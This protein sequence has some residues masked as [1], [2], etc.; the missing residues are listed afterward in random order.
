M[1]FSTVSIAIDEI[2]DTDFY[3][4]VATKGNTN[5][6]LFKELLESL[7]NNF[8]IDIAA[9]KMGVD[10]PI[11]SIKTS[12]LIIEDG[13]LLFTKSSPAS[14]LASLT[15]NGSNESVWMVDRITSNKSVSTVDLTASGAT[16]LGSLSVTN[17][18]VFGKNTDFTFSQVNEYEE[19][20]VQMTYDI[21]TGYGL[22]TLNL[23]NASRK[24]II[25]TLD[26]TGETSIYNPGTTSWGGSLAGLKISLAVDSVSPALSGQ[27]FTIQLGKIQ[28]GGNQI[29]QSWTTF[30]NLNTKFITLIPAISVPQPVAFGNSLPGAASTIKFS[31]DPLDSALS[32]Y[33]TKLSDAS[34][35]NGVTVNRFITTSDRNMLY[36]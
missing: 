21:G 35:N 14:I 36:V 4:E 6:S 3:P 26:V 33:L 31:N 12:A 16:T 20:V 17:D 24:H 27:S 22:G 34:G 11:T 9:T 5:A 32:L 29:F 13:T 30:A 7:L 8:E 28:T 1:A 25:L 23:T 2:L 10:T 19:V 15:L 18:S